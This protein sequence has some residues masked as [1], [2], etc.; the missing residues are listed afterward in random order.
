MKKS[1]FA[2]LF[3]FIIQ[4]P[5]SQWVS[6]NVPGNL[7]FLNGIDFYNAQTGAVGGW[8][9]TFSPKGFFSVGFTTFGRALYT[10]NGGTN[11]NYAS[12]PDSLR[13]LIA[14]QYVDQQNVYGFG[15][16]NITPSK[17]EY[18]IPKDFEN[19]RFTVSLNSHRL[20]VLNDNYSKGMQAGQGETRGYFLKS[21][22]S[23]QS[24]HYYSAMPVGVTYLHEGV[25]INSSTGFASA[26]TDGN[27]YNKSGIVR[28][29]NGG[30]NWNFVSPP[31]SFQ[32]YNRMEFPNSTTGFAVGEHFDSNFPNGFKGLILRTTN[33]GS[34]WSRT[35]ISDINNFQGVSFA[36]STTGIACGTSNDLFPG[37]HFYK[38]TNAG[39]SW[40][41]LPFQVDSALGD[42]ISLVAGT[43]RGFAFGSKLQED[44]NNPG[45]LRI[46]GYYIN[47]TT[48]YGVSWHKSFY[49]DT[50]SILINSTDIDQ[51]TWYISGGNFFT[52]KGVVLK[53]TNGGG[54]IGINPISIEIP[55]KFNVYQNYPNPFN[56]V[57]KIKFDVPESGN[58][59]FKVYDLLGKVIYSLNENKHAGTYEINFNGNDISSGIYYYSIEANGSRDVKKMVL[60]K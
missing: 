18:K 10:S 58:I 47:R 22:N 42:G 33:G 27:S 46:T 17:T 8:Y 49:P 56:P 9:G 12:I 48:D 25:F 38:T 40:F 55:D 7:F 26:V 20:R 30:L 50:E 19:S 59:N 36:N 24:W 23:G 15:V 60:L 31:D 13:I 29:T 35:N 34:N 39:A 6:Q 43:G 45:F 1:V 4:N 28:T 14:L 37:A 41:L 21:T 11:W 54:P 2:L 57:T 44:P 52:E 53:T 16:K 51:N 3:V 5:L 32:N